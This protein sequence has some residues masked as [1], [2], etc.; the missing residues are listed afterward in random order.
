MHSKRARD[1]GEEAR[2]DQSAVWASVADRSDMM[3]VSSST[4]S[5]HDVYESKRGK[6]VE[7]SSEIQLHENQIGAVL[8]IGN[9]VKAID[10]VSR[11]DVYKDLHLPLIQGYCLDALA[12]EDGAKA[13]RRDEEVAGFVSVV[14]GQRILEKDGIGMGRD[15][16]F[17]SQSLVGAGLV[18]G[19]ELIQLSAFTGDTEAV[20]G[21]E[22]VATRSRIRRPSR[23]RI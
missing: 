17:E 16:R 12:R 20:A 6:L 9:Q 18:A 19:Q 11:T 7:M 2:A 3:G 8:Q 10:M 23:R 5:M 4:G 14:T 21:D 15:F 13:E 1:R 22:P